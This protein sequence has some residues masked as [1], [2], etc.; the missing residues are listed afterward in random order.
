MANRALIVDD[1]PMLCGVISRVMA[2]HGY[3]VVGSAASP[4]EAMSE[5]ERTDARVVIL[6]L[7]L[8]GGQ[9]EP[10][11]SRFKP[12]D[13]AAFCGAMIGD[14]KQKYLL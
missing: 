3:E 5:V 10:L 2:D 6:D 8:Q 12:P 11:S 14:E 9:G 13:G 7:A 1:D 4:E